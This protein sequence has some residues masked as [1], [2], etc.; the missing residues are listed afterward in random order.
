[1]RL[2]R[3]Q[4]RTR[5][6]CKYHVGGHPEVSEEGD[7]RSDSGKSWASISTVGKAEKRE[8]REGI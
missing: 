7:I 4:V 6:E 3:V 5:W 1:M 2:M 8:V